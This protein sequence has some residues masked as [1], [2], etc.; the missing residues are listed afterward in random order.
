MAV[1]VEDILARR[2]GLQFFDWNLAIQAAP[3]VGKIL[4]QELGWS[5]VRTGK[6]V[7]SYC[8]KLSGLMQEIRNSPLRAEVIQ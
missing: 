5:S 1:C 4:G 3:V 6:E 7:R 2:L 8:E